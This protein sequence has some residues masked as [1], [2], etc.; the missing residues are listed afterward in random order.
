MRQNGRVLGA[1]RAS[2]QLILDV[3]TLDISVAEYCAR[4]GIP[5]RTFH[6]YFARKPQ[7]IRPYF[8]HMTERFGAALFASEGDLRQSA[9]SAFRGIVL[10]A[11]PD[12]IVALV[13]ILRTEREYWSAFL[14][15]VQA[16]EEHF[17]AVILRRWPDTSYRRAQVH[18][19]SI[20]ASSRLALLS[21]ANGA[22]AADGFDAY[23][24]A[25]L[26][27]SFPA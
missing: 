11:R 2:V 18:A 19:T 13:H 21:A 9:S 7:A 5:E 10:G 14:E 8:E 1:S 4:L 12:D 25:F 27:A 22:D 24:S 20:V 17:S 3:G 23:L 16:S 26:P 6:R 15:V